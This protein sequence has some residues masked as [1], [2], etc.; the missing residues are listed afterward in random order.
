VI[1]IQNYI[2]KNLNLIKKK[3]QKDNIIN[4]FNE[5]K[6]DLY[7]YINNY[8]VKY[9]SDEFF[10]LKQIY[11]FKN[12]LDSLIVGT[13]EI[14]KEEDNNYL[15]IVNKDWII[16]AKCFIE[17][18]IKEKEQKLDSFYEESFDPEY[19]YKSYFNEK[20]D[21]SNVFYAFPGL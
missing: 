21:K 19:I 8:K 4:F 20:N 10:P 7:N 18:Y 14:N 3:N 2:K 16:K 13:Y 6:N 5:R 12:L 15:Y 17:N 9:M 1:R 11:E